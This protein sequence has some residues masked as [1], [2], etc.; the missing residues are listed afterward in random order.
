MIFCIALDRNSRSSD[1]IP[2][3]VKAAL[4]LTFRMSDN[5]QSGRRSSWQRQTGYNVNPASDPLSHSPRYRGLFQTIWPQGNPAAINC[6]AVAQ[7][8]CARHRRNQF[9]LPRSIWNA[10]PIRLDLKLLASPLADC[11]SE[12]AAQEPGFF[13]RSDSLILLAIKNS[14]VSKD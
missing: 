13:A 8:P 1:A 7:T 4:W 11:Q 3:E 12:I 10:P 6:G 9:L 2:R 5:E 14:H